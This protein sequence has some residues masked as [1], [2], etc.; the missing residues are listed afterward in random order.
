MRSFEQA[1]GVDITWRC[2][3][4]CSGKC[5]CDD[6]MGLGEFVRRGEEINSGDDMTSDVKEAARD[7][8]PGWCILRLARS[9]TS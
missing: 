2:W 9:A 3:G 4:R 1:V 7:I 8:G 6:E 5:D